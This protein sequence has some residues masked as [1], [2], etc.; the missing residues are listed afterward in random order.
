VGPPT[1]T[2][3]AV[4]LVHGTNLKEEFLVFEIL[5]VDD[6]PVALSVALDRLVSLGHLLHTASD[7]T[8]MNKVL[9]AR[10]I[11]VVVLDVKLPGLDGDVLAEFIQRNIEPA[12][13]II[14]HSSLEEWELR[15]LA[16]KVKAT[17]MVTK[18]MSEDA[19]RRAVQA[20]IHAYQLDHPEP[21]G[22]DTAEAAAPPTLAAYL[23]SSSNRNGGSG[24]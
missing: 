7:W 19:M 13:K 9:F 23:R 4:G 10:R 5:V 11:A 14:L 20:A 24:G 6:D 16:R 22:K 1:C 21:G 2:A 12:P 8:E 3:D 15:R 18:T 17:G